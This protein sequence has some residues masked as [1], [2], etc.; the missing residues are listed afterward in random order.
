MERN[1]ERNPEQ[2]VLRILGTF[3]RWWSEGKVSDVEPFKRLDFDALQLNLL[4]DEIIVIVGARQV[5]KSTMIKQAIENLL[6]PPKA[7]S[8]LEPVDPKRILYI[9]G[10]H[11]GFK[12]FSKHAL[13]DCLSI[14]QTYILKEELQKVKERVYVFIDEVHKIGEGWCTTLKNWYDINKKIKFIVSGSSNTKIIKECRKVL[15]GR[16]HDQIIVPF[17]FLERLR[18][19]FYENKTPELDQQFRELKRKIRGSLIVILKKESPKESDIESFFNTLK[20]YYN[21]LAIYEKGLEMILNDYFIRG[22][23]PRVVKEKYKTEQM[24]HLRTII[25][26]VIDT[27]LAEAHSFRKEDFMKNL[28]VILAYQ[29]SQILNMENLKSLLGEK[30]T[31]TTQKY[32]KYLEEGLLISLSHNIRLNPLKRIR[33][34]IKKVYINDI[35]IRNYLVSFFDDTVL[36][37]PEQVGFIAESIVFNHCRRLQYN[38]TQGI[39][40]NIFYWKNN[41]N[42]VDVIIPFADKLIPVEVKYRNRI[43]PEDFSGISTFIKNEKRCANIGFIVSKN[44]LELSGRIIVIP[45]ILFLLFC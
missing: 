21:E 3:N 38:I 44:T 25:N 37:R 39:K 41:G 33:K 12:T 28:L 20:Y 24:N 34:V 4:K 1:L 16:Y 2:E 26:G 43:D 45:M 5:G 42:E 14:Y 19:F 23:Y 6:N 35:G 40:G 9:D 36:T 31:I 13:E 7:K 8:V 32:M 11:S 10:D 27:D 22:G 18:Y 30:S 15:V 29:N 17:K